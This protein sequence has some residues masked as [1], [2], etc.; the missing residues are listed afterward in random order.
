MT[1]RIYQISVFN[2]VRNKISLCDYF[3]DPP[4]ARNFAI[5]DFHKADEIWRLGYREGIKLIQQIRKG[6]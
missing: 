3:I 5:Y 6:R 4:E 2:T 1:E